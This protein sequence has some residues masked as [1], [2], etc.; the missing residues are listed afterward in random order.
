MEAPSRQAAEHAR[1][2][3]GQYLVAMRERRGLTRAQVVASTRLPSLLVGAIEDGEAE[4][5]PERVFVVNALKVYAGVVGLPVDE[6][7]ERFEA[8]PDAPVGEPFDPHALEARRR[9]R[10]VTGLWGAAAALSVVALWGWLAFV[11]GVAMA[12]AR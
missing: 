7:V 9:A 4:K 8:L 5:W 6:T 12:V 10:A 2:A 1:L 11:R 3:F